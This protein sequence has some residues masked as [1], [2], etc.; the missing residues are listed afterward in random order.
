M[1]KN[2]V[3]QDVVRTINQTVG[4]KAVTV[5]QIKSLVNQAKMI[6]RTRGV[7]G[8]MSFA[9][10]LPYR[11]FT[12][13]EIERLQRSPRWYELSGKMIDLMVYEGVITPM[14]AR[15]LKQRL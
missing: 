7:T 12:Q 4:R 3:Y 13:Q 15:M 11:M 2:Q 8:L 9:S 10:Q 1:D 5:E 6:R 14:E